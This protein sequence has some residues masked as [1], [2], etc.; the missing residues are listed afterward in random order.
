MTIKDLLKSGADILDREVLLAYVLGVPREHLLAH[1]NEEIPEELAEVFS[2]YIN[3]VEEGEPVAYITCEKEFFGLNFYVDN[4]VLIPR[5][6]TEQLVERALGYMG[7][8]AKAGRRFRILDVG[9]GSGN[10]AVSI[11]RNF[12]DES[13]FIDRIDAVDRDNDAIDVAKI[14]VGQYSLEDKIHVFQSD[15]L[16]FAEDGEE[17][18]VIISNLPYIGTVKNRFVSAATEKYEPGVALFGGED[19]LE[20]YKKMFQQI[21]EKGVKFGILIGEFG[22][23]Q[24]EDME[25]VLNKYFEQKWRIEKDL[26]GIDRIFMVT[27]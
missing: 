11:A 5:P 17:Y 12:G 20:L 21:V 7:D 24:R 22:F 6:E 23:A 18:D 26:A 15:L 2:V 25:E 8:R 1:P 9:T 4:R 3:R 19:G 16:E 14:N 10:I 27:N 13:C